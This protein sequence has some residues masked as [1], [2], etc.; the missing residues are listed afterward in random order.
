MALT[1]QPWARI[2]NPSP[3]PAD[4]Q[5]DQLWNLADLEFATLVQTHLVPREQTPAGRRKWEELWDALRV[6][7]DLADRTYNVL[8]EFIDDTEAALDS[9]ALE[10]AVAKRA[11]KFLTQCNMAWKRIDRGRERDPQALAWAGRAGSFE[12]KA[13]MV[14]ATLVAAVARHRSALED[15]PSEEDRQLW[16]VLAQI[17]L[18]PRDYPDE[19]RK[20]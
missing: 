7:D 12:P 19:S 2:K 9:G 18:D 13:R 15:D 3:I 4:P 11:E 1:D 20:T 17:N 16:Q 10:P 6:D 14:I 8:E 5:A